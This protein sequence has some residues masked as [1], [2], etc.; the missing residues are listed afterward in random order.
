MDHPVLRIAAS[1]DRIAVSDTGIG[2]PPEKQKLIFEA[3]QQADAGTSRKYGGTGLGSQSAA[4]WPRCSAA[5]S[6]WPARRPG[7]HV[8]ALPAAGLHRPGRATV[9]RPATQRR[10]RRWRR[11]A[12]PV[13]ANRLKN[14]VADDRNDIVEGDSVLLIVDDDPHYARILLGM[15]RDK[16]FKGIVAH[17]GQTALSLARNIN[18]RRSRWTC[19]CRTCSAGRSSTI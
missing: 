1:G 8:H 7:Q 11:P 9:I 14:S 17:R 16:G 12:L 10:P 6:G 15:A 4:N 18:Q 2:I 3:F 5:K 19:S 13:I